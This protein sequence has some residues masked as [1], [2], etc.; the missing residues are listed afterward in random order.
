[1]EASTKLKFSGRLARK[2]VLVEE[3]YRIF[4]HWNPDRSLRENITTIRAGNPVGASNQAWLREIT[5]TISNRFSTGDSIAP[6]VTLAKGGLALEAWK[7]CLLWHLG[8][9][10]GLYS[11]FA[12]EF[13]FP[14]IDTGVAVFTTDDVIPF[15]RELNVRGV[16]EEPLSDYGVR[17]LGRDLLRAAD[18]FGFVQG[19]TRREVCHPTI[20]EDAFLYAIY[21]LWDEVPSTGRLL[22]SERW[23][24]FL[25]NP[26]QVEHELLN[27]HQ[28]RRL[29][30]ERAGSVRE[31]ALPYDSLL[32][33][34]KSLV[35]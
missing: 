10:D 6:L 32:E 20:P 11:A 31:L 21:S 25:M 3:T 2:G 33:F 4:C 12:C 22:S 29:R 34:S 1:M 8:S 24:L 7:Y 5:A 13:L 27:L 17:R 15:V 23:R 28:F 9:T 35:S 16:F 30:Y 19:K 14:R 26:S 18:E